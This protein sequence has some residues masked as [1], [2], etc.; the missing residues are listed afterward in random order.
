MTLVPGYKYLVNV[1]PWGLHAVRYLGPSVWLPRYSKVQ[2]PVTLRTYLVQTTE[3]R[4]LL[5]EVRP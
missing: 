5:V 1:A 3:L 2:N 4:P